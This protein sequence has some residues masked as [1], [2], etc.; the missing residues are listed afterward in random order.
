MGAEGRLGG[1][2]TSDHQPRR[3]LHWRQT[4]TQVNPRDECDFGLLHNPLQFPER[5]KSIYF[6]ETG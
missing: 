3:F 4:A 6:I 5:K 2:D 1:A